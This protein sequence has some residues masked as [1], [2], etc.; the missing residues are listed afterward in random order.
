MIRFF[1]IVFFA[2]FLH[3]PMGDL[4]GEERPVVQGMT[5][6]CLVKLATDGNVKAQLILAMCADLSYDQSRSQK[7]TAEK[8]AEIQKD[9]IKWYSMAAAYGSRLALCEL[10]GADTFASGDKY[11]GIAKAAYEMSL[12]AWDDQ[13]Q[14]IG[15]S[16]TP[17]I[18]NDLKLSKEE[19]HLLLLNRLEIAAKTDP[20]ASLLMASMYR[21]GVI[22]PVN[23]DE[24]KK[25]LAHGL[26]LLEER[27]GKIPE[28]YLFLGDLYAK[29]SGGI[30]PD[31]V[32][33][34]KYYSDGSRNGVVEC[35]EK[36]LRLQKQEK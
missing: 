16:A 5:E 15:Y 18:L 7:A 13:N 36:L 4:Y 28:H 20:H 9:Y 30:T 17:E 1:A 22:L 26:E 11:Q 2:L 10:I 34:A 25:A 8:L 6:E 21:S 35:D 12:P 24:A 3:L 19:V 14:I 32:K 31:S 33:A 23:E 29:G 27:A